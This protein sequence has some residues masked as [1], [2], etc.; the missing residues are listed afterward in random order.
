MPKM[1]ELP[2]S[3]CKILSPGERVLANA[4]SHPAVPVAGKMNGVPV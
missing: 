2:E 3:G 4:T 1:T